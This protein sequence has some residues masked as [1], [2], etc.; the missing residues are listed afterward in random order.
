MRYRRR[1]NE[2]VVEMTDVDFFQSLL[3]EQRFLYK[4]D[5]SITREAGCLRVPDVP[6]SLLCLLR[7][8]LALNR[9]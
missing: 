3:M 5:S 8:G 6:F 7:E 1:V 2:L 4:F 9:S